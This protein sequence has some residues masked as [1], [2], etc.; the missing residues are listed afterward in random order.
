M[1]KRYGAPT[2]FESQINRER[3]E[4]LNIWIPL[5][6]LSK[7]RIYYK[8]VIK[9][10]NIYKDQLFNEWDGLCYYTGKKLLTRDKKNYN[11]SIYPTVD[12]K[13]SIFYGFKNDI[14]FNKIGSF[15]N[16]CICGR[17]INIQKSLLTEDQY[18]III[19]K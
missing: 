2:Y 1:I 18:S 14:D 16:L 12:H 10:T 3:L 13:I 17:K 15:D 4:K 5:D 8:K 6:Q 9:L 19:K 11:N 7:Y